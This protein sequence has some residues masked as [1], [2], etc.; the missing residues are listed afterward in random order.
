MFDMT[1]SVQTLIFVTLL[2][3]ASTLYAEPFLTSGSYPKGPYQPTEFTIV[4]GKLAFSV[5]AE[6]LPD[7]AVR[8]KFDLAQLPDGEH[9]LEIK[10]VNGATGRESEA[11][12]LRLFKKNGKEVVLETPPEEPTKNAPPAKKLIPPS[13][14]IRNLITH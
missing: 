13:R 4:V 10:A 11:V 8:L 1:K 2:F 9:T 6:K 12:S 7:G 14:T 5:A 3:L